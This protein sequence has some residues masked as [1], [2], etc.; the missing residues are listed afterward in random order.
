MRFGLAIASLILSGLLLLLGIG[1]RTVFAAPDQITV[2]LEFTSESGYAVIS[3]AEI[4][5]VPGQ[6]NLVLEGADGF[7]A[8]GSTIDV[9]AWVAPHDHSALAIDED[10]QLLADP[11]A[12]ST[13]DLTP[14]QVAELSPSGSDLWLEEHTS[15]GRVPIALTEAQSVLVDL[16]ETGSIA[17]VY[18]QDDRTPWAGPLLAAGGLF[19]LIGIVLYLLA[20]DHDRRGLGPRRGRSGPLVGIR[21]SLAGRRNAPEPS[22]STDASRSGAGSGG[23]AGE[24]RGGAAERTALRSRRRSRFVAAPALGV[25]AMLLLS[26]CSAGYWPDFSAGAD[27]G[28]TTVATPAPGNIAP[29]PLTSS[30]LDRI[31]ADI[32]AVA[33]QADAELD[34]T[35]LKPRFTAD[36]L[37]ARAANYKIRK[38]VPK[39]E[40]VLPSITATTLDYELVQS[41]ETW[42]RVAFVTVASEAPI[43]PKAA[44]KSAAESQ[45]AEPE[46]S[47]SLA[48][49]LVQESPFV[50]FHVSRLVALRGG[51]SMPSA[52]PAEE[53]TALLADDMQG[54]ALEPGQVGPHYAQVLAGGPKAA[55]AEFFDL[56]DDTIIEK[57]GAAWVAAARKAAKKDKV[58]VKYSVTASQ[59]STPITSLST[60][61]GGAL[62]ATTVLESRIERQSGTYQPKAVGAVTALSK[63]TGA[64]KR[65]VSKVAHELLFFVPSKQSG[66][67]I[68]LLGYTTELVGASK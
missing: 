34:A 53:G 41:T 61:V 36:A 7:V 5:R 2:P 4:G 29:V 27:G 21:N 8:I 44:K 42:P 16:G 37:E 68:Q 65:I 20:V 30:Q 11:V 39:Y 32:A 31:V 3:A 52:A 59:T 1:Q 33:D 25:S 26:G 23:R 6:S 28:G 50:N 48:L 46:A 40:V 51:I 22:S 24:A 55:Q 67:K 15:P 12:G 49:L 10:A 63:L 9:E 62:V 38:K 47:P 18:E 43:D 64:Q 54:L 35:L 66:G 58:N 17:L 13:T 60:G 57:S 56:T 14:E 19:A 45:S